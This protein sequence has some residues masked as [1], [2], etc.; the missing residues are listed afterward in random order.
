M[1]TTDPRGQVVSIV[2][3]QLKQAIGQ[4]RLIRFTYGSV[5]RVAEPHDYGVQNGELKLLVYQV[6]SMPFSKGWRLL[7]VTKISQLVV[8]DEVFAGSRGNP[9]QHHFHWDVLF[10]RVE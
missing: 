2:D 8:L 1:T 9:Q 5:S 6:R 3:H 4:Q 10:A 7:D